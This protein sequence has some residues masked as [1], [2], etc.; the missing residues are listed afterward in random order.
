VNQALMELGSQVCLPRAPLCESCPV[1]ELCPTRIAG[2]QEVI[3]KAKRKATV[4]D[5]A[6]L[7]LVVRRGGK[8]LLRRGNDGERWAGLWDFPRFEFDASFTASERDAA[9]VKALGFGVAVGE[10]FATLRHAVTRFRITL[11]CHAGEAARAKVD[12]CATHEQRW[13]TLAEMVDL[14]L[15]TTGRK[16]HQL[17]VAGAK[18]P[19]LGRRGTTS[20]GR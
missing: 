11:D 7:L 1:A 13:F 17:L 3:P 6:Q 14:P 20:P 9:I 12:A 2:L 19:R 15:N 8:V 5:V 4:T 10:R 16:V 18:G